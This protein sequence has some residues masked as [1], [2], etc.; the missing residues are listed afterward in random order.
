MRIPL[1]P[2][3]RLVLGVVP[4]AALATLVAL[5]LSGSAQAVAV[6]DP[7][8]WIR[9]AGP[10][11]TGANH[12]LAAV[13]LGTLVLLLG[14][15]PYDHGRA[16]AWQ[17]AAALLA[18]SAPLWT[19][20]NLVDVLVRYSRAAGR[21]LGGDG[22]GQELGYYLTEISAGRSSLLAT[23]LIALAS[24]VAVG[25][26]SYR[27]AAVAAVPAF[28]VLLPWSV[29]GHSSA[30]ADHHVAVSAMWLHL[31]GVTVWVGGLVAL[32]LISRALAHHQRAVVGRYSVIA[33]WCYVLIG[34]SG[35]ISSVVRLDQPGDLTGRYGSLLLVK[36]S[37]FVVLGLAGWWHRR[38]TIAEMSRTE[39]A[40]GGAFWRLAGGEVLVMGAVTG[41]AAAL[42]V[43]PTP[44][45]DSLTYMPSPAEELSGSPVPPPPQVSTWLQ[46]VDP[47][48]VLAVGVL[49]LAG[50]YLA[51]VVRLRSR[52]RPWPM[53]RTVVFSAGAGLLAWTVLG[54]PAV[55]GK[56]MFSAHAVAVMLLIA[57]IAPALALGAP[58]QLALAALPPRPDDSRG[59]REW[60]EL[61]TTSRPVQF[62]SR[63]LPAV[64]HLVVAVVVLHTTRLFVQ[65]LTTPV[66]AVVMPVYLVVCGGLV[67]RALVSAHVP[68]SHRERLTAA[69]G[70]LVAVG[71]LGWVLIS[72]DRLLAAEHF[73]ALGLPWG[74][75]ALADQRAGAVAVWLLGGVP[76]AF[77]TGVVALAWWRDDTPDGDGPDRRQRRRGEG[78]D[79][80]TAAE[81]RAYE[82]MLARM[83][84]R[85]N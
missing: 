43:T 36:I 52:G 32:C 62:G 31:M 18:W 44:V 26:S 57:V 55:Y 9:W 7:G 68:A 16:P 37:L 71:L 12:L 11:L 33:L 48:P 49:A 79:D 45:P 72:T 73:G 23:V 40:P 64:V 53:P 58:R 67:T 82:Q 76:T 56:V 84:G 3:A 19:V 15:L 17:R 78:V 80:G 29:R 34:L 25:V 38:R 46:Y 24:V 85:G 70:L 2:G 61:L 30:A 20:L 14:V 28:A 8:P 66:V 77:L 27:S 65:A 47:D 6:A 63:P 54:G 59:P 83:E 60:T 22:F 41:V 21:R 42:A 35:V 69:L 39:P 75:D 50:L 51:G 5:A 74:V 1:A 4:V 81:R 13:V 10:V